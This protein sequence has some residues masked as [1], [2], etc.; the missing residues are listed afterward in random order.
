VSQGQQPLRPWTEDK[1]GV[2]RDYLVPY[3]RILRG[4]SWLRGLVYVDAFAS[5]GVYS[6]RQPDVDAVEFVDGSPFVALRCEPG[7]DRFVFVDA[8]SQKLDALE[9]NVQRQ[10]PGTTAEYVRGDANEFLLAGLSRHVAYDRYE[11]GFVFLDPYGLDVP[12]TS[13]RRLAD[14]K[15]VD[16]LVNF[17]VM[18]FNRLLD[19]NEEPDDQAIAR[20]HRVMGDTEWL[21]GL[22]DHQ[23]DLFGEPHGRRARLDPSYVAEAYATRLREAFPHVSQPYL[24]N[25]SKNAPLH[26]LLLASHQPVAIK[27]GNDIVSARQRRASGRRKQRLGR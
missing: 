4:R 23:L 15:A 25:N 26:A 6:D 18:G 21:A 1:L 11:R 19:R 17:S 13:V 14:T 7:F 24:V 27:I 12:L 2:L 22:Y 5:V 20:L 3:C 9:A 16:V 10:F 8:D